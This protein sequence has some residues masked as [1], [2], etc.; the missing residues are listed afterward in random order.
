MR[1]NSI[2]LK[3]SGEER[4]IIFSEGNNLVH[5]NQNS[6]GKT[7]LL[8]ILLYSIGF[9]V[10]STKNIKFEQCKIEVNITTD[11][12]ETISL[13]RHCREYIILE[14]GN[15]TITYILPSQ[16]QNLQKI[17]FQTESSDI[18][19][20]ILGSFY[21]DQEKGW[22]L[23]NR[24]VVIGSNRFNIE[25]LIRGINNV[26][27]SNIILLREQKH[28]ELQKYKQMY[29][30]SKYQETIDMA[31]QNLTSESYNQIV[32]SQ[33][34][35]YKIQKTSLKRELKRI[36]DVLQ[37]N[38]RFQ[39]FIAD[40]GLV[41]ALPNGE[42]VA[43]TEDNIIGLSDSIN[44]LIT[45]KKIISSE[46]NKLSLAI[47]KLEKEKRR[48]QQQLDF[49]EDSSNAIEIFDK[50]I[51]RIPINAIVLEKKIKNTENEIKKLNQRI[52]ALTRFKDGHSTITSL[53][54]NAKKYLTEL[55]QNGAYLTERYLF[56]S[57]L[58][59]LSGAI[60]HNTVFSFRISCLLEI[61]KYLNIK[62]PIILDSPSGKEI[63]SENIKKLVNILRR[64]FADH[65]IIIASIYKYDLDSINMIT[66]NNRLIEME[67]TEE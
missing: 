35:Q 4:T 61:E 25:E 27:C 6:K 20:N 2:K 52:R 63:D 50:Q 43:V 18:L 22:T 8:R 16:Q 29:S 47:D 54:N 11:N 53:Y 40:V 5:S 26:D 62:L 39:K 44:Y 10:P 3:E 67:T 30:V 21:F 48:E 56:T 58:K 24:G 13:I 23:L 17:I 66:I 38:E 36:D 7:T 19:N 55:G 37:E 64:D 46:F 1:F 28:Q 9:N 57:N 15:A 41:I 45:K 32:E 49:F 51:A 12:G 33:I 65:Q 34:E 42:T 60:L 14:N 31:T 59:E